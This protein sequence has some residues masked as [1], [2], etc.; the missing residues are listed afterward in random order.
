[1]VAIWFLSGAFCSWMIN[2]NIM[3]A[4]IHGWFGFLYIMYLCLG[5]GGGFDGVE[6][7]IDNTFGQHEIPVQKQPTE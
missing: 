5:F 3:W 4:F 2:H 6:S 7:G 1:M